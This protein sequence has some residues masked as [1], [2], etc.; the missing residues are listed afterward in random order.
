MFL[1]LADA[2]KLAGITK[3]ALYKAVKRGTVSGVRDDVSG[4]WRVDVAELQRV[5][6]HLSV[7]SDDHSLVQNPGVDVSAERHHFEAR[8]TALE[9]ERDY[10]RQALQAESEER[11]QL[12]RLLTVV[13]PSAEPS[14]SRVWTRWVWP[15][16][17]LLSVAV[18]AA[19]AW[20]RTDW[21]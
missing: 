9:S 12:V 21:L 5:Y 6:P 3:S 10:L 4:E 14:V 17:A 7:V 2:A 1:P 13:Q 15:I 18:A 19:L 16:V 8:I 20:M 11:R